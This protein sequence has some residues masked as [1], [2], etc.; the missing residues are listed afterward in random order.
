[1]SPAGEKDAFRH[2]GGAY[3]NLFDAHPPFCIDGNFAGTAGVMEMLIQSTSEEVTPL[4]ALP[5]AWKTGYIKGV[6]TR[7][8]ETVDIEWKNGKLTK[9][10]KR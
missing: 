4:P 10:K 8:G 7:T 5:A 3:P 1:M 6:R 9:F 2:G